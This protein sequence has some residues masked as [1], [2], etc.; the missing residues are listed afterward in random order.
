MIA[1]LASSDNHSGNSL[2]SIRLGSGMNVFDQPEP[3]ASLPEIMEYMTV[4]R[5]Y[6]ENAED[7]NESSDDGRTLLTV[8]LTLCSDETCVPLVLRLLDLGAD[9]NRPSPY[10]VFAIAMT[11]TSSLAIIERL[12]DCG[13]RVNDVFDLAKDAVILTQPTTT[14]LDYAEAVQKYLGGKRVNQLAN[15]HAGG[16]SGR[17]K[18]VADV[19]ELLQQR[20]AKRLEELC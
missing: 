6:L 14:L 18:F 9:P 1:N 12:L 3:N 7:P 11:S 5:K 4:V 20:G 13:L 2:P 10:A 8:G 16:L 17:S 15:K 19:I